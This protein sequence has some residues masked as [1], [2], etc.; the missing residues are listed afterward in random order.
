MSFLEC[1]EINFAMNQFLNARCCINS[2]K[3]SVKNSC[4]ILVTPTLKWFFIFLHE[5]W[6]VYILNV[7]FAIYKLTTTNEIFNKFLTVLRNV[8]VEYNITRS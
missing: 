1:R 4:N 2:I 6:Q 8:Q 3:R 5:L 7:A